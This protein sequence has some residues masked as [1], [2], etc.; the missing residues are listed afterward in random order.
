VSS[1]TTHATSSCI[2][3][4]HQGILVTKGQPLV[5]LRLKRKFANVIDGVDLSRVRKGQ[6]IHLSPRNAALLIAEGWAVP[7][8]GKGKA[9]A[10]TVKQASKRPSRQARGRKTGRP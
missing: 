3:L 1:N 5:R 2:A 4:A 6:E 8:I 7:L 10:L 9:V